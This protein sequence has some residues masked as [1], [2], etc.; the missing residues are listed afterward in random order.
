[1][2]RQSEEKDAS[3][4][5]K[6][7]VKWKCDRQREPRTY[8]S[9]P[10][11]CVLELLPRVPNTWRAHNDRGPQ[12]RHDN[13][14]TVDPSTNHY[15][16]PAAASFQPPAFGG[17]DHTALDPSLLSYI[18][19]ALHSTS[20]RGS[21]NLPR[22]RESTRHLFLILVDPPTPT[23]TLIIKPFFFLFFQNTQIIA[24]YIL[25]RYCTVYVDV[26]T[27]TRV[28]STTATAHRYDPST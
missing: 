21:W 8:L 11:A 25:P 18:C 7:G 2:G 12:Q 1:M 5:E 13:T 19:T 24:I 14:V 3:Q 28:D 4:F 22:H 10:D 17:L 15:F 26:V 20:F 9:P 23:F 27:R 16:Q 6:K